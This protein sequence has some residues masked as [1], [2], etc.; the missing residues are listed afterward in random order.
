MKKLLGPFAQIVT[1]DSLPETGALKDEQ[2]QVISHGVILI[3]NGLIAGVDEF[4]K[5]RRDT[6]DAIMEEVPKGMTAFPG[7]IDCHLFRR[8]PCRGFCSKK[9]WQNLPGD[10]SGRRWYLGY[11]NQNQKNGSGN[12]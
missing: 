3:E 10:R 5:L 7:F 8:E 4:E 12:A 2:L 9:Q 1:M 11:G 6:P